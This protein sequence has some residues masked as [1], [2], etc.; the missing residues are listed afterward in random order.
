MSCDESERLMHRLLD[1]EPLGSARIGLDRHLASCRACCNRHHAARRLQ[2]G[3]R[4]LS[5]PRPPDFLAERI[6]AR[7]LSD[8]RARRRQRRVLSAA[9]LAAGL[10]IAIVGTVRW[11]RPPNTRTPPD[12]VPAALAATT[13]SLRDTLQEAGDLV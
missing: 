1:G 6:C 8:Q 11:S 5:P 9:A 4:Y 10:L 13:P 2:E 3:L 12:T 7:L